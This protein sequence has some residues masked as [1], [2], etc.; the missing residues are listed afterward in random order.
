MKF[1][2][3][4]YGERYERIR[5]RKTKMWLIMGLIIRHP[6]YETYGKQLI[7][8]FDIRVFYVRV[9]NFMVDGYTPEHLTIYHLDPGTFLEVNGKICTLNSE[10]SSCRLK[11]NRVDKKFEEAT[12]VNTDSIRLSGGM[13]LEVMMEYEFESMVC[14]S[15]GFS[16]DKQLSGYDSMPPMVEIC[17]NPQI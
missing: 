12:F 14:G 8:W 2:P 10:G 15:N 1:N 5:G 11:R 16:K 4:K 3:C 7:S 17:V 6:S 9:N 13:K